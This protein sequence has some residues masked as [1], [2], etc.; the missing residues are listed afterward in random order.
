M[1]WQDTKH[2]SQWT[3]NICRTFVQCRTNVEDVGSTLNFF[4][5]K[6]FVF[7]RMGTTAI[8]HK[9]LPWSCYHSKYG[10]HSYMRID[11]DPY[12]LIC[13]I[14]LLLLMPYFTIDGSSCRRDI[15][16]DELV[17][18]VIQTLPLSAEVAM[19]M[20]RDTLEQ[21]SRMGREM[22]FGEYPIRTQCWFNNGPVSL[23]VAQH[24]LNFGKPIKRDNVWTWNTRGGMCHFASGTHDILTLFVE[25]V[26]HAYWLISEHSSP[27]PLA[28]R[29]GLI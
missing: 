18:E 6:C 20:L 1:V 17:R 26:S 12:A 5:Y 3:Q 22:R 9:N 29:P 25:L 8:Y 11:H 19:T 7:A 28:W 2:T 21:E 14:V 15:L 16:P 27:H 10:A 4:L 24:L 23:T 13:Y